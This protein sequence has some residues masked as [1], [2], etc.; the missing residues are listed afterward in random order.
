[1]RNRSR[2]T[3]CL[4]GVS[5]LLMLGSVGAAGAQD[6]PTVVV[7]PSTGLADGDTLSVT[8]TGF[9]PNGEAF[10][11]GQCVTPIED[12]LQQC[13]V[14]NIVPVPLDGDGAASFEITVKTGPIGSG[15]C[16][17]G[18]D[19]CVIAVGSLTSPE[20]GGGPIFFGADGPTAAAEEAPAEEAPA[21]TETLAATGPAEWALPLVIGLAVVAGGVLVVAHSKGLHR[22][23]G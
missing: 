16:G 9:P 10:S 2:A 7:E 23:L 4:V 13:D 1:M 18:G 5:A 11:S 8:A 21:E 19:Q 14:T 20:A 3:M 12:F 17:E 22:R 15:T 6:G